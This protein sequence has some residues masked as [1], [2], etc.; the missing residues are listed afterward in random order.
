[1]QLTDPETLRALK[2]GKA[3]KRPNDNYA[4]FYYHHD[5]WLFYFLSDKLKT[6]YPFN[7]RLDQLEFDDWEIVPDTNGFNT[8]NS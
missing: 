4:L 8:L 1:M 5:G 2:D 6:Y 3:V 7:F